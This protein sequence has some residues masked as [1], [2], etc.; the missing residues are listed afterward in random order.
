MLGNS[1]EGWASAGR[2]AW[3]IVTACDLGEL[4]LRTESWILD[5]WNS[6]GRKGSCYGPRAG[7]SVQGGRC[8]VRLFVMHAS[9]TL[10]SKR[11]MAVV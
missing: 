7:E 8:S 1:G 5:V 2:A 6:W 9:M 10:R 3:R 11:G 4:G